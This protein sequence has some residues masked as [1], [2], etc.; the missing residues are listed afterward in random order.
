[1]VG[2]NTIYT[3]YNREYLDLLKKHEILEKLTT[4]TEEYKSLQKR[5]TEIELGMTSDEI[6]KHHEYSFPKVQSQK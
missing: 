5:L 6:I 4:K 2:E 3:T 1:M